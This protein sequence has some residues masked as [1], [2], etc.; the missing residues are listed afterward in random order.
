MFGSLVDVSRRVRTREKRAGRDQLFGMLLS[1]SSLFPRLSCSPFHPHSRWGGESRREDM[2]ASPL[3]SL[4]LEA[5]RGGQRERE[6]DSLSLARK[7]IDFDRGRCLLPLFVFFVS[8]DSR[9]LLFPRSLFCRPFSLPLVLSLLRRERPCHRTRKRRRAKKTEREQTQKREREPSLPPRPPHRNCRINPFSIHF[10][11]GTK[12]MS[13]GDPSTALFD[14][15]DAEYCA[16]ATE[17][18]RKLDGLA[19]LGSA[20]EK[21]VGCFSFFLLFRPSRTTDGRPSSHTQPLPHSL[22]H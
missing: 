22:P 4:S 16:K 21:M 2:K 10:T 6:I 18:A 8:V 15:Y 5:R 3:L 20:G 17:V 19:G 13:S 11:S 9:A 14:E 12:T 1:L 7:K